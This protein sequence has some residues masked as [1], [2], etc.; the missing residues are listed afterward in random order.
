MSKSFSI[1]TPSLTFERLGHITCATTDI[2]SGRAKPQKNFFSK[3]PILTGL[4]GGQG[5]WR[6]QGPLLPSPAR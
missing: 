5:G 4:T 1:W 6:G 3:G 2:F